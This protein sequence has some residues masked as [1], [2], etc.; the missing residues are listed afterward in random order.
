MLFPTP[1]IGRWQRSWSGIAA[2]D[3]SARRIHDSYQAFRH[4]LGE[5]VIA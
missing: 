2:N 4:L 1:S 3:A 5:D